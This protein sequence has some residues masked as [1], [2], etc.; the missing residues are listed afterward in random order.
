M[1]NTSSFMPGRD[2]RSLSTRNTPAEG[3]HG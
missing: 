1:D 3:E 2:N